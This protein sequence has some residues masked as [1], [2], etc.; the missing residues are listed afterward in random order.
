MFET[1]FGFLDV[2]VMNNISS[3]VGRFTHAIT[4]LLGACVGLFI[5]YKAWEALFD[6]QNLIIM[7][8]IK[9]M[10]SL[11]V[12]TGIALNTPWYLE[13][14]VPTI[15]GSGDQITQ[16]LLGEGAGAGASL[17][18]MFDRIYSDIMRM[19]DAFEWEFDV[20]ILA[21]NLGI[22]VTML[23]SLIGFIPFLGIATAYLLMAKIMVSFLLI[24]GPLFI[25]M[26]FF[27]STRS[28]FTAWTGQCF[29]YV[30][31]SV[32]YPLAFSLA[33]AMLEVTVFAGHITF[34]NV[35]LSAVMF[36][37]LCVVSTQI[38][39]LSSTL[40]GGVGI[41]GL[42]GS[43]VNA[44]KG[45]IG[46]AKGVGKGVSGTYQLGKKAHEAASEQGKGKIKAG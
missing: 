43:T 18:N 15:L 28:F 22:A 4:P 26:A 45:T 25:M 29:N 38:P 3:M 27:P 39:V 24:L 30:L 14:I 12:V 1:L 9:T 44:A 40:S 16:A 11:S 41:S 2:V 37:A 36:F 35:L 42:V 5:V 33:L 19:S 7:E 13:T 31:L 10:A 6:A 17:Q 34:V 8:S 21:R 32:L 46:A 23:I 20:A